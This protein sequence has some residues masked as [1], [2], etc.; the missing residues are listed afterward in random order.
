MPT[1]Q[2]LLLLQ[3]GKEHLMSPVFISV[4]LS[5][6]WATIAVLFLTTI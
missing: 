6:V 4:H 5:V 2:R 3:F 1:L